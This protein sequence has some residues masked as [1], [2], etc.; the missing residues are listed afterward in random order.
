[1]SMRSYQN[2]AQRLLKCFCGCREMTVD[3]VQRIYQFSVQETLINRQG[4][5]LLKSFLQQARSG[6]KSTTEQFVEVY[7]QCGQYMRANAAILTLDELDVLVDK[8]L[9]YHLEKE[10]HNQIQTGDSDN[11]TRCLFRI[12]GEMRNSIELSGEY[13]EYKNAILEKLNQ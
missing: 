7:E 12:Q 11:I 2:S 5:A 13:K 9:P 6:D 4:L 8:G 10:L 1:M 3:E